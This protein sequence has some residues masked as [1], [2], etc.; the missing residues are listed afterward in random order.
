MNHLVQLL[1][2]AALSGIVLAIFALAFFY[3]AD[4]LILSRAQ[5]ASVTEKKRIQEANARMIKEIEYRWEHRPKGQILEVGRIVRD[6]NGEHAEDF[7]IRLPSATSPPVMMG[8]HGE[9]AVGGYT[10][11]ELCEIA[12]RRSE[13]E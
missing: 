6:A 4:R 9:V 7:K 8:P 11:E 10:N 3:G 12:K 2:A 13:F 5:R 1:I